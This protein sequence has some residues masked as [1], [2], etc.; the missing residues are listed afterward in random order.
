MICDNDLFEIKIIASVQGP[1][2]DQCALCHFSLIAV[3]V[4]GIREAE[5]PTTTTTARSAGS[6][7]LLGQTLL[8]SSYFVRHLVQDCRLGPR[9]KKEMG[10]TL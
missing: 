1:E 3:W 5:T 9:A 10:T 8:R 6:S 7:A 2:S 4:K